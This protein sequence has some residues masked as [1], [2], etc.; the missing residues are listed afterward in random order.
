M[1]ATLDELNEGSFNGSFEGIANPDVLKPIKLEDFTDEHCEIINFLL[2]MQMTTKSK[3]CGLKAKAWV[4][5]NPL[6]LID[7][8]VLDS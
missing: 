5:V 7:F 4:N 8:S 1:Y 6:C 2:G 3:P